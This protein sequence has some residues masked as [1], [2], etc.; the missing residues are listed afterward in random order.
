MTALI[1]I[2]AIFAT[3]TALAVLVGNLIAYGMGEDECSSSAEEQ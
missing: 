1:V 2:A 3:S